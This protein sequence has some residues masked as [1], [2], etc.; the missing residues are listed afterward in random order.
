MR[1]AEKLDWKGLKETYG[2]PVTTRQNL[3]GIK[4][5]IQRIPGWLHMDMGGAEILGGN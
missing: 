2:K 1:L 5:Q 4:E 3:G